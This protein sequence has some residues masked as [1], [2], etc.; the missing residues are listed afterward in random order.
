M[1]GN[2]HPPETSRGEL[3]ESMALC[4]DTCV[5]ENNFVLLSCS[6]QDEHGDL[7]NARNEGHFSY[8][9]YYSLILSIFK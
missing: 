6:I 2:C 8:F 7:C 5:A 3:E 1:L 9:L 4:Q